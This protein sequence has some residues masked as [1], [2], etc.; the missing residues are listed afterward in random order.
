MVFVLTRQVVV[1]FVKRTG[2]DL[3]DWTIVVS[4]RSVFFS[5]CFAL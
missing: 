4:T 2:G 3:H 5:F 1:D